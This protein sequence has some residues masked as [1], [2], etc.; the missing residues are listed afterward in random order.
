MDQQIS[1]QEI[2][3]ARLKRIKKIIIISGITVVS[4][5]AIIM[6]IRPSIK[7]TAITLSTAQIGTLATT[8]PATG[9]VVPAIE[10]IINSPITTKIIE[11]YRRAG[12]S[13][14]VGT[15]L[16]RLDLLTADSERKKLADECQMKSHEIEQAKISNK[17]YLSNLSM[18][19]KVKEMSVNHTA[20]IRS[21]NRVGDYTVGHSGSIRGNFILLIAKQNTFLNHNRRHCRKWEI[22]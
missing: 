8:I 3:S 13:V 4:I 12:D 22:I 5:A 9:I 17:T 19:I 20:E 15:P 11:V 16:L 1:P 21:Q 14:D 2:R 10:E 18:Q 6:S 7:R